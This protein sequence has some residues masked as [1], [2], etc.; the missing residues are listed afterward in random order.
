MKLNAK[1][2][3]L[4]D[5][6]RKGDNLCELKLFVKHV[7]VRGDLQQT[8]WA[9]RA[10]DLS[11]DV[12]REA[13]TV[14]TSWSPPGLPPAQTRTW[15]R[16]RTEWDP[17]NHDQRYSSSLLP[18]LSLWTDWCKYWGL[19]LVFKYHLSCLSN[20]LFNIYE[21]WLKFYLIFQLI[22]LDLNNWKLSKK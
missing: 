16:G 4:I 17:S 1:R 13:W 9:C 12:C 5:I 15:R 21:I 18:P 3:Y 22:F 11:P 20:Y 2:M 10:A 14:W 8:Q 7:D 6:S 19:N